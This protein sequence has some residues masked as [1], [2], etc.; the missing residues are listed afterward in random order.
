MVNL[1]ASPYY[2]GRAGR[3]ASACSPPGPP[4]PRCA[5][6]YVNQVGGQ[7][8]LVFDGGSLVLD[9]D[10]RLVAAGPAVRPGRPRRR[11]RRAPVFRKRLLDPRGRG[12]GAAAGPV[13]AGIEPSPAPGSRRR[14]PR[15]PAAVGRCTRSTRPWCSARAT[16]STRTGSPTWSSG[17]PAASTRRWWPP[18]PPT[19]SGPTTCTGCAMP[20]RYSSDQS[21]ARRRGAGRLASASS[22]G[23]SPSSR[24]TPPSLEMLAAVLRRPARGPHRGKPPEPHPGHRCSWPCPTSSGWMVLTTGNKSEMAVG[25]STLYGDTAGGFAVIKDVPKTAGLRPLPLTATPGRPRA[26]PSPTPC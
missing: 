4:T 23:P 5:L 16:T 12:H 13:I 22:S 7:D 17:S 14:R 3:A 2:A 24:P 26:T 10:G 1:N 20:S 11:R 18:S 8:E 9:A 25:Y 21:I 19:P 6:V 15:C